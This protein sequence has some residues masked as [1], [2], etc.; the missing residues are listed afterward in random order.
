[1]HGPRKTLLA[2]VASRTGLV[3]NPNVLTLGFARRVATYKRA[4]L[5][6]TDPE[7]LVKIAAQ[8]RRAADL[9]RRQSASARTS[10]ARRSSASH[11]RRRPSS[12]NDLLQHRLPRELRVGAGRAAHRGRGCLGQHAAASL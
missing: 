11:S 3:L 12:P 6:F 10:R 5:M 7:R 9:V 8:G 2:E 1:M 4:S